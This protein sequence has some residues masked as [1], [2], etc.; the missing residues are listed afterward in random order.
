M[1]KF[2]ADIDID[3]FDRHKIL[4]LI[5]YTPA[6]LENGTTHNSGIYVTEI[7]KNIITGAASIDY[8]KAEELGYFKLDILNNSFYKEIKSPEHLEKLLADSIDWDKLK[9]PLFV[10][11][12]MHIGNYYDIISRLPEP[13]D[14]VYKLAIFLAML[15]PGKK[16]LLGK[17][18]DVAEKTI[19]EKDNTQGYFFKKAHAIAYAELVALQMRLLVEKETQYTDH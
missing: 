10:K 19:W 7:P 11:Q 16:H 9:N 3:F 18:W 1:G 6:V 4:S 13:I 8:K 12:L 5:D 15:R 2:S 14:S 17:L